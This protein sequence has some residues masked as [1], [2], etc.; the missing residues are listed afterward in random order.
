MT[1]FNKGD[2]VVLGRR[3]PKELLA[4]VRMNRKRTITH[5]YYNPTKQCR[6]FYLGVNNRGAAATIECYPFRSYMLDKPI[7]RGP[8]RPRQKRKYTRHAPLPQCTSHGAQR[9][10]Q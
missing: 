10:T 2:S 5:I 4:Q 1:K 6:Y 9:L 7:P 3:T 8:G